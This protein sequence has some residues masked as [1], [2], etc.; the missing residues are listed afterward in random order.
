MTEEEGEE[1]QVKRAEDVAHGPQDARVRSC[2]DRSVHLDEATVGLRARR[3]GPRVAR[4]SFPRLAGI[5][6]IINPRTGGFRMRA[7]T[8]VLALTLS[9]VFVGDLQAQE[10]PTHDL[11]DELRMMVVEPSG[12]DHDRQVV[13]DFLDRVDVGEAIAASGLDRDRLE[14]RV[15]TLD[16]GAVA[17]LAQQM[18]NVDQ[19]GDLIGGNTVV[20]STTTIIIVLLLIILLS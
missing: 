14:A 11:E 20:I 16:D 6:Q 13:R 12:V 7:L 15:G 10:A 1:S 17:E 19:E 8:A 9:L 18:E 2:R 3:G 5:T 4:R